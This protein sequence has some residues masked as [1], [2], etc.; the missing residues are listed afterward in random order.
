[1][2]LRLKPS[3]SYFPLESACQKSKIAPFT[4]L[5]LRKLKTLP[6]TTSFSPSIPLANSPPSLIGEPSL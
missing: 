6:V 1:L 2:P 4:G 3:L 5:Q